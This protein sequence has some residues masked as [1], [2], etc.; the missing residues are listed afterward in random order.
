MS[1]IKMLISK[2]IQM[3]F[4]SELVKNSGVYLFFSIIAS[5]IN[6]I[7]L[8]FL[9]YYLSPN[10]FGILALFFV[11]VQLL[12]P[13]LGLS[14]NTIIARSYYT[15]P[16]MQ[17]IVNSGIIFIS[18]CALMMFV[19]AAFMP[20]TL[21]LKMKFSRNLVYLSILSAYFAML[22]TVYLTIFQ[23]QKRPVMWGIG[24][25]F[26]VILSIILTLFLIFIFKMGYL[27]RI[28]GI[29]FGQIIS[30]FFAYLV[31]FKTFPFSFS[32]NTD[33]Y[34]Y[35]IR[36]GSPLIIVALSGWGL[37]SI[38]RYFIQVL[39]TTYDLGQ[40][41]FAFLLAN[42]VTIFIAA[43]S[44]A[45]GPFA[46][47]QLKNE[48]ADKLFRQSLYVYGLFVVFSFLL[49]T[50]GVRIFKL[51]IDAQFFPALKIAPWLIFSLLIAGLHRLWIPYV[52]HIEKTGLLSVFTFMSLLVNIL[53]NI[54]FIP[55]F[56]I[57][58]AAYSSIASFSVMTILVLY[59]IFRNYKLRV[60]NYECDAEVLS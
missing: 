40:Y 34:F 33:H 51:V 50:I 7:F 55:K 58:G 41:A 59:F 49:A 46:Y 1:K 19:M 48:K 4:S 56:G 24:T 29:I 3:L 15:R 42:P 44:R 53:L 37:Y 32:M 21:F 35:F 2:R 31:V 25:I 6:F 45:W 13:I 17:G 14:M 28:L 18:L 5:G 23:F 8:P 12:T 27:A 30:F 11:T 39:L 36:L 22:L 20:S 54:I 60:F 47:E 38:D 43:V 57:L 26:N 9:S 10:D 52:L 16:D